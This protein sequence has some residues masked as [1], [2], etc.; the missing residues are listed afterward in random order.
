MIYKRKTLYLGIGFLLALFV[1]YYLAIRSTINLYK[2]NIEMVEHVSIELNP[3]EQI[4][5]KNEEE[6]LRASILSYSIDSLTSGNLL[7]SVTGNLCKKNNVVLKD[8]PLYE[9]SE[10]N[11]YR[12][13][14][15][16]VIVEGQFINLLKLL[17]DFENSKIGRV[18]SASFQTYF[19]RIKNKNTLVLTI[20]IQNVKS[21]I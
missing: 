6:Q 11:G 19:N 13:R 10:L 1:I 12:V 9:D 2:D 17:N 5:I 16:R 20:Y 7:L 4:N 15:N 8:V 3:L 18:S 21:T 14:T